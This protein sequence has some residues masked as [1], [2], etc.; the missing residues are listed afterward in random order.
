MPDELGGCVCVCV[1][2]CVWGAG[3]A[4]LDNQVHE[5]KV[6][7][8]GDRGVGADDQSA[9]HLGGQVDVLTWSHTKPASANT[10]QPLHAA[11]LY[12]VL[13]EYNT[14]SAKNKPGFL[15]APT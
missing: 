15:S 5:A 8:A 9:V 12:T 10:G 2:V 14:W 13:E 11:S 7:V 1:C 4:D 6:I 3:W